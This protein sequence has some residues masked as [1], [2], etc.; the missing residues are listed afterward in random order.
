MLAA[1]C[2]CSPGSVAADGAMVQSIT[3]IT[4]N[5]AV[6]EAIKAL[7]VFVSR[8]VFRQAYVFSELVLPPPILSTTLTLD[9]ASRA[10]DF[11]KRRRTHNAHV[12]LNRPGR[13]L[14]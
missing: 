9:E 12:S 10:R 6:N 1:K 11:H 8:I 3:E 2:R 4:G 13:P 7:V 5:A 14:R